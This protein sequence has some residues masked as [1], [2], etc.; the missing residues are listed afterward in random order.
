MATKVCLECKILQSTNNF[1]KAG[2][3]LQSRCK[4][5]HNNTRS[6]F[7]YT[8]RPKKPTGFAKLTFE[9]QVGIIKSIKDGTKLQRVAHEFEIQYQSLLKWKNKGLI[10]LDINPFKDD[11]NIEY[12]KIV[13]EI[14]I[15]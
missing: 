14:I 3:F 5:C 7:K 11:K 15:N 1:Y 10:K 9:K 12:N 6:Q 8:K 13:K 4:P 2:K